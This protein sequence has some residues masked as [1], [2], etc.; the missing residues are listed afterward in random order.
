MGR[1]LGRLA[2]EEENA[3]HHGKQVKAQLSAEVT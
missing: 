3:G 1:R 2:K